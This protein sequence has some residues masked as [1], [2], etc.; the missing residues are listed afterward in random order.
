MATPEKPRYGVRLPRDEQG[1]P[2]LPDGSVYQAAPEVPKAPT[3]ETPSWPPRPGQWSTKAAK[4][5]KRGLGLPIALLIGG[6]LCAFIIAPMIG[7]VAM[8]MREPAGL[9]KALQSPDALQVHDGA[10]VQMSQLGITYVGFSEEGAGDDCTIG[11]GQGRTKLVPAPFSKKVYIAPILSSGEYVFRCKAQGTAT[12]SAQY[13][14]PEFQGGLAP[15]YAIAIQVAV[16]ASMV[17]AGIGMVL[18][19]RRLR[20]RKA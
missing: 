18:L 7:G 5:K 8:F 4:K 19:V 16:F 17:A 2:I 9:Q 20:V 13:L 1:R 3:E 15:G 12:D 11:Q 10:K 6:L 14:D